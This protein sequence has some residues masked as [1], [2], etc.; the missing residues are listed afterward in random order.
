MFIQKKTLMQPA[1]PLS[2]QQPPADNF[3]VDLREALASTRVN[4]LSY[5]EFLKAL[6]HHATRKPQ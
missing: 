1:V 4:E 3:E 6:Q 5:D 2:A